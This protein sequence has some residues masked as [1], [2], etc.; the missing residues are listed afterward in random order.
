[1]LRRF[2]RIIVALLLATL[3][4]MGLAGFAREGQSACAMHMQGA[5]H[6]QHGKHDVTMAEHCKAMHAA[7]SKDCKR[8]AHCAMCDDLST[9]MAVTALPMPA[10]AAVVSVTLEPAEFLLESTVA[11][12]WRPPRAS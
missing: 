3:P 9:S 8:G 6:A 10:P 5:M 12:L 4:V 1:M 11:D 2:H 7:A